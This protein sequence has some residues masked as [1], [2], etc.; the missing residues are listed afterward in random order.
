MPRRRDGVP[1]GGDPDLRRGV[2]IRCSWQ[3]LA[4]VLAE[5]NAIDMIRDYAEELSPLRDIEPVNP[6]W[7]RISRLE[8]DGLYHLWAARANNTLA[9]FISFLVM[10]HHNYRNTLFAFDYG[11]YLS[12]AFRNTPGRLGLHMWRSVENPLRGM[13]VRF[14]MVHDGMRSLM[15]FFLYLGYEPRGGMYWKYLG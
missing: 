5:P 13:G 9:G 7:E 3:P 2:V 11:H 8:S 15:P 6:D 4:E 14:I 1:G 12:P 10:P